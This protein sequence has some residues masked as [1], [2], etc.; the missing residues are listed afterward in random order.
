[1]P[2]DVIAEAHRMPDAAVTFVRRNV[3]QVWTP[4]H[5]VPLRDEVRKNH[6]AK[7]SAVFEALGS[8]FNRNAEWFGAFQAA[9]EMAV[10]VE[11]GGPGLPAKDRRVLRDLWEN[12][13]NAN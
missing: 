3:G 12:L 2:Y 10:M 11:V 5:L 7:L 8:R 6:G 13:L 1:M 4:K 9:A